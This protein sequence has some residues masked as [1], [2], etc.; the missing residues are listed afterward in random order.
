MNSVISQRLKMYHL[1]APQALVSFGGGSCC[2]EETE[3]LSMVIHCLR[4]RTWS[5]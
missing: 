4:M 3:G 1:E 5:L 2:L